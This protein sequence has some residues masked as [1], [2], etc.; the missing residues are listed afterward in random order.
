MGTKKIVFAFPVQARHPVTGKLSPLIEHEIIFLPE[1]FAPN[2]RHREAAG[3]I[4]DP[5]PRFHREEQRMG[6]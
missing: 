3:A 2:N 4:P 1:G 6:P 5:P